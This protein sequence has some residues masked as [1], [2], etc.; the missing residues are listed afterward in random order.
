MLARRR[1]LAT[2]LL[3]DFTDLSTWLPVASGLAKLDLAPDVGPDGAAAMRCDFDFGDGGG[4]VVARKPVTVA[5]PET[6]ALAFQ[7]RGHG[8]ANRLELKL[9]DPSG[10]NVWWYKEEAFALPEA[11]TPIRIRSREVEFA[12]GPAGGG[13]LADL[14]A[15]EFALAAGPGG[16]GSLWIADLRLED[17]TVR[18]RPLV[19]ASSALPGHPAD[20]IFDR[21]PLASWRSARTSEPQ[22]IEVDFGAEREYGGLTIDWE[23]DGRARAFTVATSADG[24]AWTTA[25]ATTHADAPR[26]W[27]YMPKTAARFLRLDLTESVGGAGFGI[28][29][30]TVRPFELSRS[31]Q[32]FFGGVAAEAAR[33]DY[34]RW[35]AREQSYWTPVGVPDG[36]TCALMNEE[37]LVELDRGT[38]SVEPFLFVDGRL[39]TWADAT[40]TQELEDGSLP[41]PSSVWRVGDLTL[42]TTACA[43]RADGRPTLFLRYRVENAGPVARRARLFAALRPFQVTPPWQAFGALGG[44]R[45]IARLAGEIDGVWIDDARVVVPLSDAAAFGT[46]TFDQGNVVDALRAGDVPP[47]TAVDDAF[48]Y[49]SGALRFDLDLGPG[50]TRDV[51][52]AAP[53]G[54]SDPAA[55]VPPVATSGPDAFAR[56]AALWRATLGGVT[57]AV[58]PRWRRYVETMRSCVA[59]VLIERSGPALQPGPRRYTRAWI[60][61]GAIMATALLRVGCAAPAVEF[62][63]WYAG[64]Q[65]ADGFVPCAVDAEGPDWLV[66]HDSH[67]QLVFAVAE[68][69]RATDDRAFLDALWPTVERAVDQIERLRARRLGPAWNTDEKRGFRGLLPESAS[70][71]GYLAHPVHAYW[72]D[73][74]ALRALADAS[75]LADARGATDAAARWRAVRDAFRADVRASLAHT[76]ATRGLAYVPGSVEWADFDPTATSN[77]IALLG[78]TALMPADALAATYAEYLKGFRGRRDGAVDWSNYTA[79]EVRIVGALVH[80]GER[81]AANK[82]AEFLL[83]DRRPR[84]WNQWPEI[85]WRDPRSPG[86]IGD[87]PHAWI[88]A[89]WVLSFLAMLAYERTE[90]DALVI[91]A[92]IPSAWLDDGA[93]AVDG[94]RTRHG[95]FGFT[96][97]RDGA[98]ALVVALRGDL[99]VPAGGLVLDPP[100]AGPLTAVE[101]DG[102]PHSEFTAA[103]ATV[104]ACPAE[105][106]LRYRP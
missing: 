31:P 44:V 15:I 23:P 97:R 33:G 75:D 59:H 24:V 26:S 29:A 12:W 36:E 57:V 11:W 65:R 20:G 61:D 83:D 102:R 5:M 40:V 78:E 91:G 7:V 105:I 35:L 53:F 82:L 38:C 46:A 88:G 45:P 14:G 98:D 69:F 87:V 2:V 19:R 58:A 104:R 92:G 18:S 43:L 56:A 60:R 52:L 55:G 48:G 74:W 9:A 84:P 47:R 86:H 80:L 93:V 21:P 77:A 67:G 17:L 90:D 28:A 50:T 68:C 13:A 103:H 30:I 64:F 10:R 1:A 16:R 62:T 100:P 66:E 49:A 96:L 94:L 81:A 73:F 42:R 27:V 63:R 79:Y 51:Y 3:D 34:P 101:V 6:W 8:P 32:T 99:R 54:T 37:G 72:D 89:E 85:S 70:H 22:R 4:F 95:T 76:I 106:V 71:E 25:H 39:V 41:L